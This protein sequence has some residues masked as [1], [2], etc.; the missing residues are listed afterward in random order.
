MKFSGCTAIFA[1]A[2]LGGQAAAAVAATAATATPTAPPVRRQNG[3][4]DPSTDPDCTFYDTAYDSS[5]D[6]TYF[7]DW[8]GLSHA[9]FVAWNPSVKNDCS[10][11]VV[12]N[13]Y[14]VEVTRKATTTTTT[15]ATPTGSPKPSPTQ[16]GLIDSCT[17]FYKAVTGDT[18]DKIVSKYG[19]FTKAQFISWNPAV[20]SDC[21][22]IW[23]ATYYCVGIPGT[24][25]TPATNTPTGSPKPSP[26]QDGLIDSCTTFY[27]AVTGDTCD[28]I[29]SK[30]GTFTKAQFITWNPAVLSDCSG[31]WA[32]TYYCVGIPGTPTT[33][34]TTT[35]STTTGTPKPS[36]T[37]DG[38]ISSC[39]RFY[40]AVSGD[41]C[42]KIVSKY[43]TFTKAQFITW[44]PAVG[45]DCTGL[46]A[47]TYY[48]VGI[49][50][51]PS[52]TTTTKATTTTG[53]GITTPTP[54]QDGMV[55]NCDSF[56]Y[57][58][59]G[60]SCQSIADKSGITLSQFNT[61]N[62]KVG[63]TCT[64]LWLNAY[65]CISIIGHTPSKPSTT[66][67]TTTCATAHPT[68][69]QPGSVCACKQWYKP[70]KN[71]FCADIEKKFSITAAQFNQWNPSVGSDCKGLF[72]D[73]NV[74]VKG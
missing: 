46:W 15:T 71:E 67:T 23:A 35:T 36:P 14:C 49:P 44:N 41:T 70:A 74:C 73:Y 19:T 28:K 52:S 7:E 33:R 6:C 10:G 64:G 57:V 65:V 11:L 13:S 12:G 40:K 54:T 69:T 32:A 8:W 17:T 58:K 22:G 2:T 30:Y 4:V 59:S 29:V 27:K 37:Q 3:P 25:T 20:L 39:V 51:T 72:A 56:Y 5:N 50:G 66:T 62:P 24:P 31:I 16:E 48:C 68:P 43:G 21:S 26:T 45:S 55:T 38:L 34:P 61:W 42:D 47:D 53:N 18:C 1:L 60:D 9:D 63:N